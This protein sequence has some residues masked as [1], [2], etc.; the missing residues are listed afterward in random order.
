MNRFDQIAEAVLNGRTLSDAELRIVTEA[1]D[2]DVPALSAAAFTVRRSFLGDTVTFCAIVNAKSG[3][4]SENC[5]FCAQSGHHTTDAPVHD[6]LPLPKIVAA[7]RRAREA[8]ACRLGIVT[9]GLTPR[10]GDFER[11]VEAVAAVRAEGVLADVSPGLLDGGQIER[12]QAA[13]LA[14]YHHNLETSQDFFPNICTT[15]AWEDDALA[16]HQAVA[17]GLFVCSGGLFGLGESWEDRVD[18]ALSLARLGVRS[19]PMNFLTPIPGTRLENRP[20]L[21]RAE[22]LKILALY[23]FLL[24]RAHLRVCGGRPA[25]FGADREAVLLSGAD[26][27]MIGDYLTTPGENPER[28]REAAAGLGLCL[29][30]PEDAA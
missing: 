25:V 3:R 10:G 7:A 13:G 4:C 9:S 15:H 30:T 11:L 28:D 23:R 26:G 2:E 19:V 6:F 12:L 24:P 17:A 14:G 27:L 18:L 8:G 1:R 21:S 20:I 22:S 16:V 5:A 29:E